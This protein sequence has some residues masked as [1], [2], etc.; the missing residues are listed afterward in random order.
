M[1]AVAV[2]DGAC[3]RCGKPWRS[4]STARRYCSPACR[5]AAANERAAIQRAAQ[6]EAKQHL[7]RWQPGEWRMPSSWEQG[8]VPARPSRQMPVARKIAEFWHACGAPFT[9]DLD[10]PACFGCGYRPSAWDRLERAHIVARVFDGLDGVQNLMLLCSPCHYLQP[11]S[12][13]TGLLAWVY[14]VT[15]GWV[16]VAL[17]QVNGSDLTAAWH[18]ASKRSELLADAMGAG[19]NP[20]TRLPLADWAAAQRASA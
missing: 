13:P 3:D 2:Q 7:L 19:I 1:R 17:R 8:Y 16:G 15:G 11:D 4:W 14:V 10:D 6:Q 12:D 20:L 18:R 9:V 5:Q